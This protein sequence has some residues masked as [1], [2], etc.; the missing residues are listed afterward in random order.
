MML[1]EAVERLKRGTWSG[2]RKTSKGGKY[3]PTVITREKRY[4]AL[5]KKLTLTRT[6]DNAVFVSI[7]MTSRV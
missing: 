5:S 3:R 4:T 1:L 2:G 6:K 7:D